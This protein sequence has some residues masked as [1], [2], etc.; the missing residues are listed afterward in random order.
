MLGDS[1]D[2]S[3]ENQVLLVSLESLSDEAVSIRMK[4]Q[5]P[6]IVLEKREEQE[7]LVAV[8]GNIN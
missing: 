2:P 5:D 8:K 4:P 1:E 7:L 6:A 3:L